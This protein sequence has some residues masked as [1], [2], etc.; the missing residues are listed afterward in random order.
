MFLSSIYYRENRASIPREDNNLAIE[1]LR[2]IDWQALGKISGVKDQGTCDAG[3]AFSSASLIE[4]FYLLDNKNLSLSEQ[5]IVDC[6][7]SYTTFGC[8]SGS[9]NGT[10]TFIR[11]KGLT[12]SAQYPYKGVK[13]NCQREVGEYKPA[14]THVEF[15]GCTDISSALYASPLSVAV[16]AKDWQSYR[17]GVYDGCTS[18]EVNHDILLIGQTAGNWRLKNSWG[19][20]WG[21]FGYIRLKIGNTCGICEKPA[22]GFKR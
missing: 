8:Q 17:A 11:E 12:T 4:S 2:E 20:R 19:V 14:Y 7:A 18:T 22:F 10:L 15:N 1:P 5:Q 9:R 6:S 21:E 16:N 13:N 3:Y